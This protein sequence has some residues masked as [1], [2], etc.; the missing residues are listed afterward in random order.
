MDRQT[1]YHGPRAGLGRALR[2]ARY[3][4]NGLLRIG[5]TSSLTEI[6]P[7]PNSLQARHPNCSL[8]IE[9][10]HFDNRC[11]HPVAGSGGACTTS[12]GCRSDRSADPCARIRSRERASVIGP[13]A[14]SRAYV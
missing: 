12:G 2:S 8:H 13:A 14:I 4:D 7:V 10:V 6:R 5:V 3:G 11:A 9:H 1:N